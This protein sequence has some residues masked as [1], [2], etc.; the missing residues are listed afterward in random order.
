MIGDRVSD[1]VCGNVAGCITILKINKFS[2]LKTIKT[3]L[4]YSVEM[5]KPNYKVNKLEEAIP[6]MEKIV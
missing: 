3:N 1:I 2:K 4:K 5:E 6:I